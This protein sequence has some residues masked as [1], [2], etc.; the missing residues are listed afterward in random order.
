MTYGV[1][2]VRG[3]S[4]VGGWLWLETMIVILV[5][6]CVSFLYIPNYIICICHNINKLSQ[7]GD[8]NQP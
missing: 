4:E 5:S 3:M 1:Q 2:E 6:V 8:K 7:Y